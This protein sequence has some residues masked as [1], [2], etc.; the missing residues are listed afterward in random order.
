MTSSVGG[1]DSPSTIINVNQADIELEAG[2][3][4]LVCA[5]IA[6]SVSVISQAMSELRL[7]WV[8]QSSVEATS[9]TDSWNLVMEQLFGTEVA[10]QM[11]LMNKF[12]G[13]VLA[14]GQ[15]YATCEG[16]LALNYNQLADA[17]TAP[18]STAPS[19]PV[20]SVDP[21]IVETF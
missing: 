2:L 12:L 6:G 9:F 11:G 20:S 10:P 13:A 5:D 15:N 1:Y 14:A 18:P 21:P 7:S 8:G 16:T 19:T 3:A 17:L 4:Q